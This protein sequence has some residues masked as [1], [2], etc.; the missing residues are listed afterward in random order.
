MSH[1][2]HCRGPESLGCRRGSPAWAAVAGRTVRRSRN[3]ARRLGTARRVACM[4]ALAAGCAAATLRAAP[5][6]SPG[7]AGDLFDEIYERGHGL[8]ASLKTVTCR[9]TETTTSSLLARPVV[10]RGTLAVERPSRIALSYDDPE[11]RSLQID[12]DRLTFVWPARHLRQQ[13]DIGAAQRRVEKYFVDRSP[14]ELRK[15]F[16]IAAREADDRPGTWRV[17]MIPT[18]KQILQGLARL[19]LWI[20]RTSLILTAMRMEFP[21]G[22]TKLMAFEDVRVNGPVDPKAFSPA[23]PR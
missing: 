21:N 10:A 14:G 8:E 11:P 18:R 2:R 16:R 6:S 12:R 4:V 17:T 3:V 9:F 19:D 5:V 1:Q 13:T 15:H 22:D 23:L 20:D 7:P